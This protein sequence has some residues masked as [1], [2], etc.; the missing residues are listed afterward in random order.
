MQCAADEARLQSLSAE[1][2]GLWPDGRISCPPRYTEQEWRAVMEE[3]GIWPFPAEL[4]R[5]Y[6]SS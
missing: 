5:T 2:K 3:G 1:L 4:Q 6:H